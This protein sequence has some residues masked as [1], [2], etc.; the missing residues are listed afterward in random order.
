MNSMD[1]KLFLKELSLM[2]H[3][4]AL[5]GCRAQKIHYD[6]CDYNIV[7]F[8]NTNNPDSVVQIDNGFVRLHHANLNESRI[9][10]LNK[11]DNLEII[12]DPKWELKIFLSKIN[13]KKSSISQAYS[14]KCIVES[15]VCLVKAKN[16]LDISDPFTSCWVKCAAYFLIDAI[17]S[18]NNKQNCPVHTLNSIRKLKPN[19]LN[20]SLSLITECIGF[21]RSTNSLLFRMLKSTQGFS[22]MIEKNN[23][24]K[25]IKNKADY[26][27]KNSLLSDCYFY[28]GNVNRNNFYKIKDMSSKLPEFIHI[29]KTGFDLENDIVKLQSDISTLTSIANGLLKD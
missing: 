10:I 22:D 27:I 9:E 5:G 4:I 21:E 15:Q 28:L 24:S 14:R 7:I 11:Y 3:P 29:L 25:I 16:G 6:C 17:L 12:S 19:T 1:F 26:L 18:L 23:H 8:D 20:D 13:E 2:E